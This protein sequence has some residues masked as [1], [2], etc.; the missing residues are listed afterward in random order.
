MNT[1]EMDSLRDRLEQFLAGVLFPAL[2]RSQQRHW[3]SVYVRGVLLD[4]ERKSVGAMAERMPDGNEQAMQQFVSQSTWSFVPVR[5]RLAQYM[6]PL[7]PA[8]GVIV[9]DETGFPKWGRHSVAVARQYSGTLGKVGNCQVAVSIHYAT[10]AGSLPLDFQLYLPKE[11][12]RDPARCRKAGIPEEQIQY[13]PKW[14]I[15]LD[16]IDNVRSWKLVDHIV[17]ADAF[18]GRVTEF[19]DGLTERKLQYVLGTDE[20]MACWVGEVP[21][22]PRPSRRT[23]RPRKGERYDYGNHRPLSALQVAQQLPPTAWQEITWNQGSKGPLRSRFAA[24]R[25]HAAHDYYYGV[26]PRDEEWLLIEWPEGEPKPTDYWISN[27]PA[28][29]PLIELVRFGKMRWHVEQDYQQLK[30]ELGL[31]HFEGRSWPGWNRHVTLVMIA[32]AFLLQERIRGQKGG[33]PSAP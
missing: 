21:A 9:V 4:G 1:R 15:A 11:W 29:L 19:R 30:E 7:L 17:V 3:G 23:G 14:Q 2:S 6:E 31:D 5:Q 12:V 32:F 25:I 10:R 8:D 16:L 24:V 13:R 27:L 18:Y 28:D 20:Q 22:V 33:S 26:P